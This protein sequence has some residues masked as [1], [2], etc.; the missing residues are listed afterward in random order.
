MKNA[1]F[2]T[3]FEREALI[4]SWSI[5]KFDRVMMTNRTCAKLR[6]HR[7][8]GRP[9][10]SMSLGSIFF[11]L[12]SLSWFTCV[13]ST[14][15]Y[16]FHVAFKAEALWSCVYDNNR[17]MYECECIYTTPNHSPFRIVCVVRDVISADVWES[18]LTTFDR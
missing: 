8:T 15:K 5:I 10:S 13:V 7:L 16:Y 2:V 3:S 18:L 4:F 6:G 12:I 11:I 17:L 1:A 14:T 9:S